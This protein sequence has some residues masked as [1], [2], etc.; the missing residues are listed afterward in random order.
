MPEKFTFIGR[1]L[2][3]P[4]KTKLITILQ[5]NSDH[6]AWAPEDMPGTNPRIIYHRLVINPEVRP[7][8]QKK[9]KLGMEKQKAAT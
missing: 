5:K 9:R 6:F 8:S 7:V 1:G 2:L 4:M 3:E